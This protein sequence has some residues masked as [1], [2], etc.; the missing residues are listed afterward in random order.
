M[1]QDAFPQALAGLLA[2]PWFA[3]NFLHHEVV[4]AR[5]A[6]WR[7]LP[8]SLPPGLREGLERLGL[9]RLYSHQAEAVEAALGG[10]NVVVV[11]PTASGKSLCYQLPVLSACLGEP[12]ARALYLFPTKALAQDQLS[13]LLRLVEA[14]RADIRTFTYDGDTSPAARHAIRQAGDIVVTN[15]DMLHSGILPHHTRWVKL[16]GNLRYVVVDELHTY[17]GVFGSHLANVLRRLQRVCRFYGSDPVFICCSAT[18]ANPGELTETLTGRRC[19]VIDQN[20]AP[21]GERHLLF[22]QPPVVNRQLGLRRSSLLEARRLAVHTI[23]AG[24]QTICFA[25]SRLSVEVLTAHLKQDLADRLGDSSLVR[26]YRSGYLPSERRDIE[27]GL[28]DGRVRGVVSTNALELGVDIGAMD[29]A[30]LCGFPGTVASAWQQIG[31]AGRRLEPSAAIMVATSSAVDQY[32]VRHHEY[33]LG[34]SPEAG[35]AD[36]DNRLILAAH[37]QAGAFEL[38]F[39]NGEAYGAISREPVLEALSDGPTAQLRRHGERWHWSGEAFPAEAISLRSIPADNVLIIDTT[40]Q[41]RVIGEIDQFAAPLMVHPQAIYLHGGNQFYV[42]RLDWGEKK[43]YVHAVNVDHYTDAEMSVAVEVLH[44][45]QG[46][47][48]ENVPFGQG[49]VRITALAAMFKKISLSTH[50]NVG[51]GP[52]DLPQ[53]DLHT[54]ACWFHLETSATVGL[55]RAEV[56]A[57]LQGLA[58]AGRTVAALHVMCDIRDLGSVPQVRSPHTGLPTVTIYERF[59]GGVGL[60]ERLFQVGPEILDGIL[61]LVHGCECENGCPS[62]VGPPNESGEG[63]RGAVLA[64]LGRATVRV[65]GPAA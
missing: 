11:T 34:R 54:T 16:F 10:E 3:P 57:A 40:E 53:Q 19:R 59:P 46:P 56:E 12:G 49:E 9:T 7:P 13:G 48:G 27:S 29:V 23:R 36:P 17:R 52:I 58:R 26:G 63:A 47:A 18:I 4:P 50:E 31:R 21:S 61:A 65:A 43:A 15:P 37:L 45:H 32:V 2:D 5:S 64:V 33:F 42:D 60:S 22:Y 20:G 39:E 28:R 62:C 44:Q 8:G 51:S 6:A 14:C 25:R 24:M 30:I 38:P 55:G 1:P 41:S 35:V